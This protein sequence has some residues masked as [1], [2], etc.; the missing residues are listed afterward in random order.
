MGPSLSSPLPPW[1][2]SGLRSRAHPRTT[3]TILNGEQ[4][5]LLLVQPVGLSADWLRLATALHAR[6]E[7]LRTRC[8]AVPQPWAQSAP[9][10]H[11]VSTAG[12]PWSQVLLSSPSECQRSCR[13]L[14]RGPSLL[15]PGHSG[16]PNSPLVP[17]GSG[18]SSVLR[19]RFLSPGFPEFS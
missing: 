13:R 8:V 5:E 19:V 1:L 3:P 15:V 6:R 9:C 12:A 2:C 18:S 16:L 14:G 17:V 11:L 10:Q 7:P 4:K